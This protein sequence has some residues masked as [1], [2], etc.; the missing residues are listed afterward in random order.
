MTNNQLTK[1]FNE[2]VQTII[3][4]VLSAYFIFATFY[5]EKS[6]S[7]IFLKLTVVTLTLLAVWSLYIS[8]FNFAS[9]FVLLIIG[10]ID[11]AYSFIS[12]L[13]LFNLKSG[14]WG[15]F[16]WL[17]LF[18][19]FGSAYLLL[20]VILYF[21]EDGIKFN[22][23][24]FKLTP[25]LVLFPILIFITY[26]MTALIAILFVE[27]IVYFYKPLASCFL[28][29]SKAVIIPFRFAVKLKNFGFSN[30]TYGD[31][32]LLLLVSYIILLIGIELYNEYKTF[33][34]NTTLDSK[35][36]EDE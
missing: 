23:E 26:G 33:K 8:R 6:I 4:I 15:K 10:F 34:T 12:W 13:F 3:L 25:L 30:T 14:F 5:G 18:L 36:I 11:G 22:K 7:N 32:F 1:K 20:M 24:C 27:Y 21:K 16:P 17:D 28:M 29:L 2:K 35:A 9:Y 31:W 19:F